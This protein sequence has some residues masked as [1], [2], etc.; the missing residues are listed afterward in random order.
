MRSSSERCCSP[1]S[2]RAGG[3]PR[4]RSSLEFV[5]PVLYLGGHETDLF[6][7]DRSAGD[8]RPGLRAESEPAPGLM[9][10]RADQPPGPGAAPQAETRGSAGPMTAPTASADSGKLQPV[11]SGTPREL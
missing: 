7:I 3:R 4:E 8:V 6:T 9:P 1:A 11:A 5:T 10:G 2:A